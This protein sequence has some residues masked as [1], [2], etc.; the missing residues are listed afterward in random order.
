MSITPAPT[1][2]RRDEV[3]LVD[4]AVRGD[5]ADVEWPDGRALAAAVAAVAPAGAIPQRSQ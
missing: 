3:A 2:D 1:P 4:T 5:D